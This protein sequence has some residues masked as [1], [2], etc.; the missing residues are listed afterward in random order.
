MATFAGVE[1]ANHLRRLYCG[2]SL[3]SLQLGWLQI[4]LAW[5]WELERST[6]VRG[7]RK[8]GVN[9][10][11]GA[12]W[13]VEHEAQGTPRRAWWRARSGAERMRRF[14]EYRQP[15]LHLLQVWHYVDFN[16]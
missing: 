3:F 2:R 16:V 8:S 4:S 7:D 14:L 13:G 10:C 5:L 12:S 1:Q 15:I 9:R 11:H 6:V